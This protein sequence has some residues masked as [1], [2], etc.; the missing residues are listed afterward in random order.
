MAD[1]SDT[2]QIDEKDNN[3]DTVDAV[4]AVPYLSYIAA[5]FDNVND[6]KTAYKALRDAQRE[7]LVTIV[8][9]AYAEKT[10][11]GKIRMHGREG[12]QVGGGVVAGGV[13]G[14]IIG[15]IAGT[16]L[17]PAAIGALIGG[18]IME[19]YERQYNPADVDLRKLGD[20]LPAGSTALVAIAED[21]HVE[22]V[23]AEIKSQGG[24]KTH[25]GKIPKSTAEALSSSAKDSQ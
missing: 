3:V 21:V 1:N 23:V 4:V 14:G 19:V 22:E 5:T 9:A 18:V 10:D 11:R 13:A 2:K 16:I 17:L 25:S 7:G 24:K 6:A 8:D 12:W 15:I 20:T